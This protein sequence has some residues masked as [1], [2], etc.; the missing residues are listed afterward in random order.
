VLSGLI[1][2][3]QSQKKIHG[4]RIAHGAPE[5]SHLL[6]ADDSLFF[7]RDTKK[8]AQVIKD[9]ITNYQEASGQLVNMDKSEMIFSKHTPHDQKAEIYSTLP[10]K[11]VQHFNKYLGMPTHMGRSK[12][13]IF[14]FIQDRIWKKLKGWKEKHLSFAGGTL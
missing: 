9:I 4:I 2:K 11:T 3:A 10:M 14:D 5:I 7:C 8:E 1:S 6:F 13:Q 12:R